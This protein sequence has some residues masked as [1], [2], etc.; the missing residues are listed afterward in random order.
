MQKTSRA[1]SLGWSIQL[2]RAVPFFLAG[3]AGTLC[4]LGF[5]ISVNAQQPDAAAANKQLIKAAERDANNYLYLPLPKPGVLPDGKPETQGAFQ[6]K[7]LRFRNE[8]LKNLRSEL[9]LGQAEQVMVDNYFNLYEF[10][11]LTQTSPED[12]ELLPKRRF[13]LFKLYILQVKQSDNHQKLIDLTFNM[14][15]QIVMDE[16]HPLVRYNAML[17]IGELN[18]QEVVRVGAT[19]L[20]QEPYAATIP[21]MIERIEDANTSDAVRVAAL[22]GLVRHLEWEPFRSPSKPIPAGTRTTMINAL[23]KLAEMKTPPGK[24]TAEGQL[25]LRRRAVE[26]LGLAGAVT[27]TPQLITPVEKILKDNTEPLQ[28]RCIAAKALGTM[29]IPAGQ[30]MDAGD[31]TRTLGSLAALAIKSE[32]E[33]LETIDKKEADHNAVYATLGAG[34]A[35]AGYPGGM[36]G[37]GPGAGRPPIGEGMGM[38]GGLGGPA[39]FAPDPKEYRLEPVRRRL[40]YQ[41]YCVQTG[42]GYPLDKATAPSTKR[43]GAQRIATVP[44]DKKSAEEVLTAVNRLA[45]VIEKNKID[46]IQLKTDL[47]N[48]ARALE[49]VVAKATPAP[50]APPVDPAAAPIAPAKPGDPPAPKPA[51]AD[52]DLLGGAAPAKK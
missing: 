13:D 48:E 2:R 52:D 25:W 16:F 46:L 36:E 31:L 22:V 39:D 8:M 11:V 6:A 3:L 51:A 4:S 1:S 23:T 50:V 45:D 32:F 35:T 38:P 43:N 12:L 41:L 26:C 10:K 37:M 30:K 47:K 49:G 34:G 18:E 7:M 24:R 19:P 28:L 40:R 44:A 33:R 42:L 5:L 29:N 9:P 20:P 27:A 15:Q 14:M 21:F 17:I